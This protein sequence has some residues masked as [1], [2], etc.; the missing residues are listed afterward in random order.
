MRLAVILWWMPL[1]L[2]SYFEDVSP[3]RL[4]Y[5]FHFLMQ[6]GD[7]HVDMVNSFVSYNVRRIFHILL[8]QQTP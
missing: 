4:Q 2:C 7:H 5:S 6:G 8:D 1:T 3:E